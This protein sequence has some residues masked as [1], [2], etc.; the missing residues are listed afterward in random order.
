[1]GIL[2]T[3]SIFS[4]LALSSILLFSTSIVT[5]S[6]FGD[7]F[8]ECL[9]I[10]HLPNTPTIPIY[11]QNNAS[12]ET[13]LR[14]SERNERFSKSRGPKYIVTPTHESHVQASVIC[15][16]KHGL[17][18]KVRSG[19]HD[20]EGL[21]YQSD[22]PS[23][24]ILDFVDFRNVAVDVND[25]TAWIQ[26]GAILG[27]VYYKI[28]EK[29]K[30]YG[31]P[32]G[33]APTIGVGGHI[34][35]GGVG[36]LV[37]KY[38]LSADRVIDACIVNVDGKILNKQTMGADLFWAIRG[39]GGG[40]FG[41]ILSWKVKL[42]PLPALV[43]VA[44]IQ[45]TLGQGATDLVHKWQFIAHKLDVNIHLSLM[46]SV[47]SGDLGKERTVQASF[48]ILF[49]GDGCPQKLV[50]L[51]EE[52]FPE[53]GLKIED[54]IQMAWVESHLY[55]YGLYGQPLETLLVRES[56]KIFFKQKSDHVKVPIP[57]TG[58]LELWRRLLEHVDFTPTVVFL[59]YGGKMSEISDSELPY[60]DRQAIYL[61]FYDA[62]WDNESEQRI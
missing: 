40:N 4:F 45:K 24:V 32:A 39:G 25:G 52:S 30:T 23:F 49:I 35:G 33:V 2:G 29:S 36:L 48:S 6:S 3:S 10:N 20:A 15:C 43:T 9:N 47:V 7:D 14:S 57:T 59:P 1:M 41:V 31:F 60:P 13:I 46:L 22:A 50:Q 17:D 61:V 8:L 11:T 26:A 12:Y 58:L 19:G 18:L 56:P 62:N 28:A 34:S 53:L 38:G 44:N 27:E 5:A 54:C 37:R 21:S 42:V 16:K 55:F 51:L